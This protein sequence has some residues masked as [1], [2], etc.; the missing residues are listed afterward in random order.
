MSLIIRPTPP[1]LPQV[2][3]LIAQLDAYL[4]ELYDAGDNYIV[5]L[6]GLLQPSVTF[7]AAWDDE[8]VVGCGA[9]RVMPGEPA[10][11]GRRYGEVKRMFVAPPRR[12]ER[13]AEQ[14]LQG[15]EQALRGE[16]VD[17]ALLETG[18]AQAQALRLYERS[19]YARRGP[20]GG[21]PDNGLSVFM[22]KQWTST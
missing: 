14:V 22:E 18:D 5:D 7:L 10:T 20:F 8:Q 9:V 15:L 2:Q 6:A 3:A 17:R 13:I 21:Y 16:G 11:Q 1:D 19:G 12:G 4:A